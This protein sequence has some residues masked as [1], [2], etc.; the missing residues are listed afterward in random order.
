MRSSPLLMLKDRSRTGASI[1]L[2]TQAGRHVLRL[3]CIYHRV[4][5]ELPSAPLPNDSRMDLSGKQPPQ[6]PNIPHNC[7]LESQ[8]T[9]A[10]SQAP[11]FAAQESGCLTSLQRSVLGPCRPCRASHMPNAAPGLHGNH[12]HGAAHGGKLRGTGQCC[13]AHHFRGA[14]TLRPLN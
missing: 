13:E 11:H 3:H 6:Q 12:T 8:P 14:G 2:A 10:V 7:A 4:S 5:I 9:R 1:L